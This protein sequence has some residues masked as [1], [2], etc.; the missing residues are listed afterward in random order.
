MTYKQREMNS[1]P[2]ILTYFMQ[3]GENVSYKQLGETLNVR[4]YMY[5]VP[6]VTDLFASLIP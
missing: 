6:I 4:K 2:V 5:S 1:L 3:G